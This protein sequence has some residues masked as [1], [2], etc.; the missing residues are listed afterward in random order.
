VAREKE[1]IQSFADTWHLDIDW[2]EHKNLA[3]LEQPVSFVKARDT[4]ERYLM[5]SPPTQQVAQLID[6]LDSLVK[7]DDKVTEQEELIHEEVSQY[8]LSYIDNSDIEAGFNV[9]IAP[10]NRNQDAA[11][12]ALL[13]DAERIKVAGGSGYLVG[14]FYSKNYAEMICEQYRA[15]GFFTIDLGT[16][17]TV[18]G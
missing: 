10:Q 18:R 2:D 9:I 8:L 14:S 11:I 6:V 12:S 13:P 4:V 5:A 17:S 1:L 15:L 7:I 16:D 3:E